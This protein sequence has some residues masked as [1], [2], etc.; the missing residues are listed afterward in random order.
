MT[1]T[2][3]EKYFILFILVFLLFIPFLWSSQ[4]LY[5]LGGDDSR[6]Y[7]YSPSDWMKNIALYSWFGYFSSYAPQQIFIPLNIFSIALQHLFPFLNLQK[8]LY[9]LILSLGFLITFLTLRE[10]LSTKDKASYYYPAIL[11]GL[12]YIFSP[13][14]Y[15]TQWV[16]PLS[17]I[18]G[19]A[20]YPT[21]FFFFLKAIR[22]KKLKYLIYSSAISLIFSSALSSVPRAFAFLIGML[23]FFA[24]YCILFKSQLKLVIKYGI[25]YV[26]LFIL[27]NF[28]WFLPWVMLFLPPIH[29][30]LSAALSVSGKEGAMFIIKSVAPMMNIFDTLLNL[31]SRNLIY[32]TRAAQMKIAGYTYGLTPLS[33]FLPIIIFLPPL[34]RK[35]KD[36]NLKIWFSLAIPTIFLAYCQTVN[37]G[38]MGINLFNLF[39]RYLPGWA[40]FRNFNHKFPP[41]YVFFYSLTLGVS[42]YIIS[43][44]TFKKSVKR[45]VFVIIFLIV[46]LQALP[47]IRG[48]V[49]NLPFHSDINVTKNVDIPPYYTDAIRTIDKLEEGK[50]LSL[51]LTFASWSFF[52]SQENNGMYT[53]LSPIFVFTGSNDFNG[54]YAFEDGER[55]IPGLTSVIREAIQNRNY[56]FLRKLFGLLNLRYIVYNSEIYENKNLKKV[57]EYII[58]EYNDFQTKD[59][60]KSLI[61]GISSEEIGKFGPMSIYELSSKYYYPT[62]YS[63]NK[64]ILCNRETFVPLIL[65]HTKYLDGKPIFLFS[66]PIEENPELKVQSQKKRPEVEFKKVNPT[67]YVVRTKASEPFWLV[68]S[69]AFHGGWKA[70]IKP[71]RSLQFGVRSEKDRFEWSALVNA[72]RD[73]GERIELKEHYLVNGYAN[74]WWIDPSKAPRKVAMLPRGR[75]S[76]KSKVKEMEIML[77]FVPQR[78]FEVGALISGLTLLGCVGYLVGTGVRRGKRRG[79]SR[80]ESGKVSNRAIE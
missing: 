31:L 32:D 45:T 27:V 23:I 59:N 36:L 80:W 3:K 74:G 68:F 5:N 18:L 73:R 76:P 75:Q 69:E 9:G 30:Q 25:I 34:L 20:G 33:I 43:K 8:M 72:C 4:N 70:Y 16:V 26:L 21:I 71:V 64:T 40:M 39:I 12:A 10:L 53:G 19:I 35:K 55:F 78:L 57:G 44:S 48:N 49:D 52:K 62:I 77:E 22:Q 14:V 46:I 29:G 65:T 7:F 79:E 58:W 13:L 41:A 2:N 66:Q 28:L 51:P 38:K 54:K 50:V 11:G 61:K 56:E 17:S 60:I 63:T 6:L 1:M 47:F 24:T 37:V 42:L 15:Y 67:R